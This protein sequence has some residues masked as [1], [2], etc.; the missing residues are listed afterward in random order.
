MNC[1][2]AM[3]VLLLVL[4]GI[5]GGVAV[6]PACAFPGWGANTILDQSGGQFF[7]PLSQVAS[8][9]LGG[10]VPSGGLAGTQPDSVWMGPSNPESG[11]SVW[12]WLEFDFAGAP[13]LA[14]GV[15]QGSSVLLLTFA[16]LDFSPRTYD[17]YELSEQ[18]TIAFAPDVGGPIL[19]NTLT[20]DETNYDAPDLGGPIPGSDRAATYEINLAGDLGL[21]SNDLVDAM[22][23]DRFA[24]L[25]TCSSTVQYTGA[26][27][28]LVE[29]TGTGE[30]A[31][32]L[33]T[34]VWVPE[35]HAGALL[36]LIAP[37]VL[38]KRA[39]LKAG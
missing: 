19:G 17:G 39:G 26:A 36:A 15:E 37:F 11:G 24:L 8:G 32:G 38:L 16:G 13:G 30:H 10:P 23:N 22:Q 9:Q 18:A 14:R 33:V 27:A 31:F 21:G 28:D 2:T 5:I 1:H 29:A 34:M 4:V 6:Q 12:F 3:V 35:P 25:V 7:I 20:I